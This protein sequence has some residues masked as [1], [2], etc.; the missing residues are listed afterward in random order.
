MELLKGHPNHIQCELG[1]S[2]DVFLELIKELQWLGHG[3][4]KY[5]SLEEQLVIFL[6][7]SVIGLTIRHVREQ[8]QRSNETVSKQVKIVLWRLYWFNF[9]LYS[10]ISVICYSY[11]PCILSTQVRSSCLL[12]EIP[13]P[14]IFVKIQNFGYISKMW[15]KRWMAAT[16]TA[17]HQ[18]IS[19]L[20]TETAKVLY[21]KTVFL[22]APLISSSFMHI[23]G[24]RGQ[25][26]MHEC[27][28]V[29]FQ[30]A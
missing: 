22:V 8:F 23:P 2:H 19:I 16:S 10:D 6:D 29:L 14:P 18:S 27:M 11:S 26:Q 9:G 21:H 15:L 1:V 5:V 7:M 17:H 3:N 25:R 28:R 13:S 12:L 4:S 30:M 20:L 24:G